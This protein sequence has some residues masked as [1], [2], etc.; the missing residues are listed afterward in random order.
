MNSVAS[1]YIPR[2]SP[3]YNINYINDVMTRNRIGTVSHIDFTPVNKKH[4]F[5][6][7]YEQ[8]FISAFI[9]FS[10]TDYV[11]EHIK[12]GASYKI[13]INPNEYWI[14]LLNK[15][16]IPRT[17]MNIHQ[18]VENCRYLENLIDLQGKKIELLERKLEVLDM[19]KNDIKYKNFELANY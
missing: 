8:G 10:S 2:M 5:S 6:E 4:G 16:P 13:R 9:H 3:G 15:N 11:L 18:V 12:S 14:C 1:I 7:N 17:M 19:E